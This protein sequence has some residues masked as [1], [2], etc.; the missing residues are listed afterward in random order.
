MSSSLAE[1]QVAARPSW[2][3]YCRVVDNYGDIGIAWRLARQLAADGR[4]RVRLIVDGLDAFRRIEPRVDP[5]C[6]RQDIDG[7]TVALWPHLDRDAV[8]LGVADVVV[9]LLGCGLPPACIAGM[10]ERLG[11]TPCLWIDFE[12]LSAEAWVAGFHGLPSPHP[13]LPLVKHFFYPGFGPRTG[14]LLVEPDLERRR[15]AFVA[16]AEARAALWHQVGVPAPVDGERRV[17]LFA[18]P[19]APVAA[20]LRRLSDDASGRWSVLVPEGAAAAV[21]TVIGD[22]TDRTRGSLSVTTIPFVDQDTFDR[23]LWACDINFVRGEDSFVRAQAA[24][25]P[26]VWQIYRQPD[27]V[28]LDKLNAFEDLHEAGLPRAAAAAQRALWAA[29]NDAPEDIGRAIGGWLAAL[30][31]LRAHA[32][33]W[34]RELAARA[35]LID[36]LL[37]FVAAL[38]PPPR[39]PARLLD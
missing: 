3:L 4:R 28:H 7:I 11:G 39:R 15:A 22:A 36:R 38:E 34:R 20:L 17:L 16:S 5:A 8:E 27:Q 24:G 30:P 35:P 14:G 31:V 32:E 29:W 9:E 6:R 21:D 12:H 2:D 33:A 25:R 10:V 19:D 1:P 23:L 13:R 37:E 18:Y 26:F